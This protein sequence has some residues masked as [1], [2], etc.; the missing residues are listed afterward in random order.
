[1]GDGG[2][3]RIPENIRTALLDQTGACDTQIGSARV[4]EDFSYDDIY[5]LTTGYFRTADLN[6]DAFN[7]IHMSNVTRGVAFDDVRGSVCFNPAGAVANRMFADWLD[8]NCT[9]RLGKGS[10]ARCEA[11]EDVV[12]FYS[13][14]PGLMA[15]LKWTGEKIAGA[16]E[17]FAIFGPALYVFGKHMVK[18]EA[19]AAGAAAVTGTATASTGA[20]TYLTTTSVGA[21][22]G[23][24]IA[25]VVAAGAAIG[26]GIGCG[27][28]A[29]ADEPCLGDWRALTAE[30]REEQEV[31]DMKEDIGECEIVAGG[32]TLCGSEEARDAFRHSVPR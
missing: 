28:N 30:G 14:E 9:T 16:A 4:D 31:D 8:K 20:A 32:G 21:A 2:T 24:A 23:G 15:F 12:D 25:G 7:L 17:M 6:T 27:I 10:E 19:V 29:L 11:I 22:G 5:R 26:T 1:M 13:E 3:N 18:K